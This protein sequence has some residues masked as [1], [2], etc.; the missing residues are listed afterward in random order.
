MDLSR[1]SYFLH[2]ASPEAGALWRSCFDSYT[3][4]ALVCSSPGKSSSHDD[5]CTKQNASRRCSLE[6]DS[7]RVEAEPLFFLHED[8]Y[9]PYSSFALT[10]SL[11]EVRS[12]NVAIMVGV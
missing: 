4:F 7:V 5:V 9:P 10:G 2:L 11:W 6:T 3:S 1:K 12:A 8:E